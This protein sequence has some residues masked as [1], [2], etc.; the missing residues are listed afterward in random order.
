ML[1]SSTERASTS[2]PTMILSKALP[3]DLSISA[4]SEI[5]SIIR[6]NSLVK[7]LRT[8]SDDL[9]NSLERVGK[10]QPLSVLSR[11]DGLIVMRIIASTR[12]S[13]Q[14]H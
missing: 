5:N 14:R 8:S 11:C 12:I 1:R 3:V 2:D 6:F 10:I 9:D 4:K 13:P 7:T